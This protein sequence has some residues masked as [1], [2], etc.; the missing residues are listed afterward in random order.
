MRPAMAQE[1]ASLLDISRISGPKSKPHYQWRRRHKWS[2]QRCWLSSP[3]HASFD[4]GFS[5]S[6]RE[7][8]A[9]RPSGGGLTPALDSC[10]TPCGLSLQCCRVW[11]INW[12][13]HQII[14]V[15]CFSTQALQLQKL[16]PKTRGVSSLGRC[17]S[18]GLQRDQHAFPVSCNI[19]SVDGR[20]A[21]FFVR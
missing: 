6:L 20:E 14:P 4:L 2:V 15:I 17:W 16:S 13:L 3:E 19:I 7:P 9:P 12:A 11:A 21:H 18:A 8:W 5:G 1:T 10:Q